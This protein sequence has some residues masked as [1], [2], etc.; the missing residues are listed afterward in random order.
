MRVNASTDIIV[1]LEQTVALCGEH[2]DELAAGEKTPHLA[3][4]FVRQRP[5]LRLD[6]DTEQ[7]EYPG[8]H[9]VGLLASIPVA[10]AKSRTWRGSMMATGRQADW[11][12]ATRFISRPLVA[13]TMMLAGFIAAI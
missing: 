10:R 1:S 7:R 2:L 13:S 5:Y 6:P 4:L 3:C 8:L 11:R 9:G 12:T